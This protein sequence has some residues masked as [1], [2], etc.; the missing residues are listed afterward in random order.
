MAS[1][2]GFKLSLNT[3]NRK[4]ACKMVKPIIIF[5]LCILCVKGSETC[6][7]PGCT[8]PL[9]TNFNATAT[10]N[11]GSC[12]YPA[13]SIAPVTSYLLSSNV[14]ETSGLIRWNG[15]FWTMNDNTDINLYALDTADGSMVTYE[16]LSG[17]VNTD[18]EEISQDSNYIYIGDFGNNVNGNRTD[19]KILRIEKNSIQVHSP[20]IDTISF[21]YSDQTNFSP[22]GNNNTDFDCEAMVVT[23]DSVYLFTKQWVSQKTSLYVLPKL[24]GNYIAELKTTFDVQGLITGAVLLE[25]K[26]LIGLCGYT[27]LLQPFMYAL[28]D[29]SGTDFFNGN[30]RRISLSLPFYQIEGITTSDG[31]TWHMTNENFSITSTPQKLHVFDLS[32]YFSNYFDDLLQ[33]SPGQIAALHSRIFPNPADGKLTVQSSAAHAAEVKI[34][35]LDGIVQYTTQ[36]L[37]SRNALD[38]SNLQPGSYI[39]SILQDGKFWRQMFTKM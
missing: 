14:I 21:S 13:S 29:Y 35:S 8:D 34:Y 38:I 37:P 25:N 10:T 24:P 39:L 6:A 19:L 26:N 17:T 11:D 12:L 31:L 18:W 22:T 33:F 7:Q 27:T 2:E 5:L 1:D 23:T 32:S 36:I 3:F 20:V 16:A 28:Y 9:A 30:K 4:V 15:N